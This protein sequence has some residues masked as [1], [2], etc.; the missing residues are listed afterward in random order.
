MEPIVIRPNRRLITKFVLF[1]LSLFIVIAGFCGLIGL[2]ISAENDHGMQGLLIGVGVNLVWLIPALLL[3]EP[4][5][6]T[7]QYEIQD[8]E[9]IVRAG[10]ITHSVKHV[11]YRTITNLEIRRRSCS[12][13]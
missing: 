9:V 7:F 8:D 12:K 11:P 4:Y 3:A 10:I 2:I 6:E 5:Y 1:W 13:F